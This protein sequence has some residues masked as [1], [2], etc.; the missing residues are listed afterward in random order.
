M[1]S[2]FANGA[3]KIMKILF[4]TSNRVGDAVLST[5]L[6]AW[7]AAQH[8]DA[9]FTIAC[10]PYAAGLFRA[11]PGLE[12]LIVLEKKSWNRHWLELWKACVGTRWDLIVDLRDSIV[13]R[14]L[15]AGKRVISPHNTGQHKV[16]EN[17]VVLSA[18]PLY[19]IAGEGAEAAVA[20]EAGEG[21]SPN[22]ASDCK[23]GDAPSPAARKRATP[24]P[25][26]RERETV[27]APHIWLD[28]EAETKAAKIL[29]ATRPLLALAPAA[30][31]P[32]KQW[33]IERFAALAQKLTATGAPLAGGVIVVIA[34]KHERTQIE[35]LLRSIP[36]DRRVE[37]IGRDLL[38][39]AACL[40][41]CRLFVGNDSG[42]MHVAAAMG[43][44]TL[45][46]FGP[47]YEE[48]YGPWGAH[49]AVIRTPESREELLAR[50]PNLAVRGP[51]LMGGLSVEKVYEATEKLLA[52]T[53]QKA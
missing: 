13:S 6:L 48:I 7:L 36:A 43:T 42:L 45:G 3:F 30:N 10:G 19:R 12:R 51:N 21:S 1:C 14:L 27:P 41:Q 37:L 49:C 15:R 31:W 32:C 2:A 17:A 26:M 39:V 38:T 34:D 9:Q 46:L 16:T 4:I 50:L 8:P 28:A 11:V 25:A 23:I 20:A 52:L 29:P 22:W 40:R 24:F 35:P 47:G 18:V 44:P 53:V 33:P 5:G